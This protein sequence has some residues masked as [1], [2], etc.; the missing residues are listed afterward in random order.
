MKKI[1]NTVAELKKALL[2]K[3]GCTTLAVSGYFDN[4]APSFLYQSCNDNIIEA[5]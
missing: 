5:A 3:K 4:P 1:S 2:I